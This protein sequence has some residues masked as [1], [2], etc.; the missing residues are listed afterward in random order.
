MFSS[1]ILVF[2]IYVVRGRLLT[3]HSVFETVVGVA[4]SPE[5]HAWSR[6]AVSREHKLSG[7]TCCRVVYL[8]SLLMILSKFLFVNAICMDGCVFSR[9][10]TCIIKTWYIFVV[11]CCVHIIT[12]KRDILLLENLYSQ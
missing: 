6:D 10:V 8:F 1:P 4:K 7:C 9:G 3:V 12:P 5:R 11:I 2:E